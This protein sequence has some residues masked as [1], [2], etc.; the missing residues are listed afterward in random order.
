VSGPVQ[1]EEHI[2]RE[3]ARSSTPARRPRRRCGPRAISAL[4]KPGPAAVTGPPGRIAAG[5]QREASVMTDVACFAVAFSGSMAA[6]AC[7]RCG[8]V[9]SVT[10]GAALVSPGHKPTGTSATGY[11]RGRAGQAN[12]GDLPGTGRSRRPTRYRDRRGRHSSQ[13][14]KVG[15]RRGS[16][17]GDRQRFRPL[18]GSRGGISSLTGRL[19]RDLYG[20]WRRPGHSS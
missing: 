11:E 12:A 19:G 8:E 7:P 3:G 17:Q 9:A 4:A 14:L 16:I 18:P 15:D 10:A 1:G 2:G 13:A 6:R 20:R 5:E